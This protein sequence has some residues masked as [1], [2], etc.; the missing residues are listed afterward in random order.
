MNAQYVPWRICRILQ[1]GLYLG[2]LLGASASADTVDDFFPVI[3]DTSTPG[4]LYLVGGIDQRTPLNFGRAT[5]KFPNAKTLILASDG[6]SVHAALV[7]ARDVRRLGFATVIPEGHGCYSACAFVFFAGVSRDANGELG[8]HQISSDNGDLVSGQIALSDI[9]DVLSAY[10]VPDEI[11]VDMLRTPPD[12]MHIYSSSDLA[13]LGLADHQPAARLQLTDRLDD[14]AA[15]FAIRLNSEWSGP[16]ASALPYIFDQYASE[17]L[18]YGNDW[19]AE[20]V[21]SDKRAFATR[22]PIRSYRILPGT[23]KTSCIGSTCEVSTEVEWKASSPERSA[24]S[25]GVA[26]HEFILHWDGL[27]FRIVSENGRVLKRY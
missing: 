10:E 3:Y 27:R 26:L 20:K 18:F 2:L 7:M 13:I 16:N 21:L 6:G 24:F 23:L 14:K 19:S 25:S 17:V 22:W 15:T 11:I 4:T 1:V 9:I 8:V 12:D 5:D